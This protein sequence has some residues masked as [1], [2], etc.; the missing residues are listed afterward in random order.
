[1]TYGPDEI[2]IFLGPTLPLQEARSVL[3]ATY[4]PPAKQGDI[5]TVAAQL[6]PKVIGLIDGFFMQQ[7]SV[8]HKEILYAIDQ[9]IILLG[10]SS[11]GALR[12]AETAR[13]GMR[14]VGKIFE[15]Y[16]KAEVIDDDEVVL[17]HG[18]AEEGYLPLS[19]PLINVRFTLQLAQQQGRIA[20]ALCAQFFSLFQSLYFADR[21][22]SRIEK[23]AL[24][25]GIAPER[26]SEMLTFLR[27]NLIDQKKEDA[28]LL[29]ETIKTLTPSDS[30]PKKKEVQ[31]P[32]FEALYH[33]DRRISLPP[34]EISLRQIAHYAALHHPDFNTI[35]YHGLNQI[36][37]DLL[38]KMLNITPSKEAIEEEKNR[39]FMGHRIEGKELQ[40]EWLER[41]RLTHEEFEELMSK[42]AA[43]RILHRSVALSQVPYKHTKALLEELKMNNHYEEWERKALAREQLLKQAAPCFDQ[44]QHPE[45]VGTDLIKTHLKESHWNPDLPLDQWIIEAGFSNEAELKI[46]ILKSK[47]AEAHLHDLL[48]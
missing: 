48:F 20:Q 44:M 42:R 6:K 18:P 35:Q 1:M 38:A 23:K 3:N 24:E 46:E 43:V 31:T 5:L 40:A 14:G 28:R 13:Y 19:I 7:L 36:L 29:L 11:M 9:G 39:F 47:I 41:N 8:W 27:T 4:L 33:Y 10:A 22:W 12:A 45:L 16:H 15:L 25:S 37:A 2:I 21:T 17:I 32:F 30:P 34:E 26:V